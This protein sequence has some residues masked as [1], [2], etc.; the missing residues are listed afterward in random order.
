MDSDTKLL[1][2]RI[3]TA[4]ENLVALRMIDAKIAVNGA[5][6]ALQ[7]AVPTLAQATPPPPTPGPLGTPAPTGGP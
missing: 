2:A 4:L 1:L 3:A 7:L 5:S 6:P